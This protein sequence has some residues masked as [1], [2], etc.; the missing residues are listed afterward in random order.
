MARPSKKQLAAE[1]AKAD[2]PAKVIDVEHF[3]RVRDSVGFFPHGLS[4]RFLLSCF[5]SLFHLRC[6]LRATPLSF[7]LAASSLASLYRPPSHHFCFPQHPPSLAH[8][9]NR[10]PAHSPHNIISS[11]PRSSKQCPRRHIARLPAAEPRQPTEQSRT[12]FRALPR[13]R[14]STLHFSVKWQIATF[15]CC[16]RVFS[17][18]AVQSRLSVIT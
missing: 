9:P 6:A 12:A 4:P 10:C 7:F 18:L 2:A 14:I 11:A 3:I 1:A 5:L 13:K 17:H 8:Y 15:E 16:I